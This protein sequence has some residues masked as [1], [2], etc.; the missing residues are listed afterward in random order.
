MVILIGSYFRFRGG[1]VAQI[2]SQLFDYTK[3]FRMPRKWPL[4][5]K[6]ARN[7]NQNLTRIK[8]K[9]LKILFTWKIE[10]SSEKISHVGKYP[11]SEKH[12]QSQKQTFTFALN[13]KHIK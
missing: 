7:R 1:K 5:K 9:L 11:I 2:F 4:Y 10:G 8:I 3:N 6:Y 12:I 13:K